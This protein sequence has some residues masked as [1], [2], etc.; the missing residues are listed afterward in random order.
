M[1][2]N[3]IILDYG[4]SN[5]HSI[6]AACNKNDINCKVSSKINDLD[7]SSAIILP[8]VGSFPKAIS[9]LKKLDLIHPLKKQIE[10]G[11]PIL[12]IC[13][14]MQLLLDFSEE[15]EVTKGLSIISG[16]VKKFNK[17]NIQ[18]QSI[19]HIGWNKIFK[20]KDIEKKS[21]LR[22]TNNNEFMYFVHSYFVL[23]DDEKNVMS[24]TK[25]GNFKFC[26][27]L[28]QNNIFATQFHPEKSGKNG[29]KII[30]EFK[31]IFKL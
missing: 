27:S 15:F 25:Y 1:I 29:L 9:N 24:Y 4:I 14:G 16:K 13:L 10:N 23:P 11:K 31:K 22:N 28:C 2:K 30:K 26:S 21:I 19:P 5:L 6:F 12:G 20:N 3:T 18:Y 8:G 7:S 17:K